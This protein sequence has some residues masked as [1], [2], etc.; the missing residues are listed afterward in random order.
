[1]LL[2]YTGRLSGRERTIPIGYFAWEAGT[3]ISFSSAR[4]GVNLQDGRSMVE[5]S[6]TRFAT[7]IAPAARSFTTSRRMPD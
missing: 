2:T 7:E 5:E 4:W 1:M 6:I 3:V